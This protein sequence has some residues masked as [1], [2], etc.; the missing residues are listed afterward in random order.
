MPAPEVLTLFADKGAF[1]ELTRSVD[2]PAPA[3]WILQS[4]EDLGP[5]PDVVF[6][7]A[8]L[9]PRDSHAF[10]ARYGV[11][12]LRVHSKAEA[13]RTLHELREDGDLSFL[14]Q[15]Y[16]PGPSSEHYFVD[17]F[18]DRDQRVTGLFARRRLRMYPED[19]GNSS[20]MVSVALPDVGSAVPSISR[21]LQHV[22]YR[23]MFSA[24]FKR[25]ARDGLLKVLEVNVRA[26]WYVEFAQRCGLNVCRMAYQDALGM[27]VSQSRDYR[28]GESL[29]YAYYD[30]FACR[31]RHRRGELSLREW[32]RSWVVSCRPI[33]ARDDPVPSV[34][35]A[36]RFCQTYFK[37]HWHRC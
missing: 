6:V 20:Y 15:E 23:G 13:S 28:V 22:Q 33:F 37:R 3:T 12:G 17:G 4:A 32:L 36:S 1:A 31:A 7:N 5:I 26:W 19:F 25:D 14:L 16:V 29:V 11:K 9:K 8:F 2:V 18:V 10:L 24:E 34:A 27:P 21:L 35:Y 30:L